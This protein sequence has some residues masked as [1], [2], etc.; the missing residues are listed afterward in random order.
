MSRPPARCATLPTC[1]RIRTTSPAS[2]RRCRKWRFRCA[3][4]SGWWAYSRRR[5][6]RWTAFPASSCG[7]CR[8]CAITLRWRCT[9]RGVSSRNAP[10]APT[11]DREAQEARAIQQALLPKS[12]PYIP[13]FV[14]S[15]LERAGAGRGRRLVRLHSVSRRA[16]GTGSGRC[17]RQRHGRRAAHV[18]HAR[19]VA[20]AGGGVLHSGRSVDPAEPVA[21][22]RFSRGQIR[23]HGV[24]G[25]RSGD[26]HV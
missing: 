25:A 8:R 6:L 9:M 26:A 22:G 11:L 13:G 19:H 16:L 23:D 24:C 3:W 18:G 7:F 1:A 21:G 15:G 10:N 17:L 14:V 4:A 2:N 5:I 20:L 12:S